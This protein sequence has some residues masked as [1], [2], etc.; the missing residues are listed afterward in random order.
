MFQ[1]L[2]QERLSLLP[3]WFAPSAP[4]LDRLEVIRER[5]RGDVNSSRGAEGKLS[6]LFVVAIAEFTRK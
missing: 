1:G 4:T 3:T 6:L 5:S 2:E